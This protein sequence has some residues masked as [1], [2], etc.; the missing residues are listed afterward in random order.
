[1]HTQKKPLGVTPNWWTGY[2]KL[3]SKMVKLLQYSFPP[4]SN[5]NTNV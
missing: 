3:F 5:V 2:C 4:K 1:M